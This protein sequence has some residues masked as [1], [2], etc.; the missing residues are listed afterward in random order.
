V[1]SFGYS[2][3]FR[4]EAGGSRPIVC[5]AHLDQLPAAAAQQAAR[6]A[7][8]SGKLPLYAAGGLAVLAAALLTAI[9]GR[10]MRPKRPLA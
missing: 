7:S 6:P 4:G 5:A 2:E 3:F 10:R 1:N 8:S 9:A